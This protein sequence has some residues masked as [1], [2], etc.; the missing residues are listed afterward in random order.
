MRRYS[1]S[2]PAVA[3]AFLAMVV[4]GCG[5][6]DGAT[7]GR[8]DT[9]ESRQA[10]ARDYVRRVPTSIA[11]D[12][13]IRQLADKRE[14]SQRDEFRRLLKS[15]LRPRV[16]EDATIQALARHFTAEEI[17]ALAR[18]NS[19]P[20]GRSIQQ[21]LGGFMDDVM[22]PFQDEIARVLSL[23][24]AA[25]AQLRWD[26]RLFEGRASVE[27][28]KLVVDFSF[29]NHGT[30]T[31]NILSVTSTCACVTGAADR[32][33]YPPR[34][35][36]AVRVQFDFESRVGPQ[37][38][39]VTVLTD[40]PSEPS[41]RLQVDVQIP[42]VVRIEP[43]FSIWDVG[44]QAAVQTSHVTLLQKGIKVE[45]VE[46]SNI[47]FRAE[48]RQSQSGGGDICVT[49]ADTSLRAAGY[50]DVLVRVSPTVVRRFPLFLSV[51]S[52]KR[53]GPR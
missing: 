38:K 40:D 28:E 53:K 9:L 46:C 22:P 35:G 18:F 44:G 19:S 52:E 25:L 6:R 31:V 1:S 49:P 10:A 43:P 23:T 21:K 51:T 24:N 34:H 26:T 41:V 7:P 11:V 12:D 2:I 42:E 50:L 16:V 3:V 4:A 15:E 17:D 37:S 47:L 13:A 45:G 27:D 30:R 14:A 48:W 33:N 36:G 5:R 39:F 20:E 29:M 32:T 8:P